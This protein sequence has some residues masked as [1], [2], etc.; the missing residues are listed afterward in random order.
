MSSKFIWGNVPHWANDS[1]TAL[2]QTLKLTEPSTY[3]HCIRVGEYARKLARDLGLNQYEQKVALYSGMLHD[4]GKIG[5]S[6]DILLK[7]GRLEPQ[8]L[9]IMKTH[10]CL[11]EVIVSPLAHHTFFLHLLPGIRGHHERIDGQGYPDKKIGDEI[12][13]FA[14]ILSVVD[15]FDAMTETRIYRKGLPEEFVFTELIRCSQTQFDE[16]IVKCF[17]EAQPHWK[18]DHSVDKDV[19]HEIIKKV[20]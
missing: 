3:E 4:I 20:A 1:V 13:L 15:T 18:K 8:E 2:L 5:I 6:K 16:K 12:S 17:L 7:P 14:R 11:S 9:E 19:F 10:S